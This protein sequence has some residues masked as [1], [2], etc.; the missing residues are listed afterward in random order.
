ML[1]TEMQAERAGVAQTKESKASG[2]ISSN[3]SVF[4]GGYRGISYQGIE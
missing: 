1:M 4:E 3:L 2:R